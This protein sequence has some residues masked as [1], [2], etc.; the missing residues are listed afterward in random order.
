MLAGNVR[1]MGRAT[2]EPPPPRACGYGS[3]LL[4]LLLAAT[5]LR[6]ASLQKA[7]PEARAW[8]GVPCGPADQITRW[9]ATVDP[10]K[11]VLPEYPRPQ[12]V[13]TGPWLNLNGLWEFE[14][15][16]RSGCRAERPAFGR[17]LKSSVLV[18]FP[19]E[20][21]LSGQNVTSSSEYVAW[22]WYRTLFDLPSDM[23]GDGRTGFVLHFGAVDWESWFW[24]N[25]EEV[26]QHTGGYDAID[27]PLRAGLLRP[28]GNELFVKVHDPGDLGDQPNGKQRIS[29]ISD[30]SGDTYSPSTGIWQT[31]WLEA[32]PI[33]SYVTSLSIATNMETISVLVHPSNTSDRSQLATVTVYLENSYTEGSLAAALGESAWSQRKLF[34]H[35]ATGSTHAKSLTLQQRIDQGPFTFKIDQPVLWSPGRPFLYRISVTLERSGDQVTTYAGMRQ[36]EKCLQD[37]KGTKVMKLCLNGKPIFLAGWLDQSW[38]PD[39]QYTAPTDE[40]LKSDL[41]AVHDFGLNMV[42][43]HQKVNSE[44]WYYHADTLGIV[45]WQDMIQ[46][47]GGATND[48]VPL[49]MDDLNAMIRGRGNHPSIVQWETF[50]ENDCYQVFNVTAVVDAVREADPSRLIDTDSGGGANDLHIADVNDIHTYP[51]PGNPQASRTQV[52]ALGEYGGIGAFVP[53][54]AWVPDKCHTYLKVDT[55]EDAVQVYVNMTLSM[56]EEPMLSASVYTQIT[57]VEL[58]CDGF[59]N[60]DRTSKFSGEQT[61]RIKEANKALIQ[62]GERA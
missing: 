60:Y 30:P 36:Y 52:A 32:V 8:T 54:K 51:D 4:R 39:G 43:L 10:A 58:E 5:T 62:Q 38:W 26:G 18:P 35:M 48:T 41:R 20:S 34:A 22:G 40:A 47:Y 7:G 42:R 28:H 29:A 16:G 9:G 59:L 12:L 15:C 57:D 31:V 14:A 23:H 19:L 55:P 45:V 21:C 17:P 37:V 11:P 25:G 1:F 50:N 33:A 46:K 49:F 53:G 61:L 24:L 6:E 13:R 2:R 3:L 27:L 56:R 44:R